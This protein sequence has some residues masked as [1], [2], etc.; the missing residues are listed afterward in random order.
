V[1]DFACWV[2][3]VER[4]IS[5][6]FRFCNCPLPQKHGVMR[7]RVRV[8]VCR[9]IDT[10]MRR[11]IQD[12]AVLGVTSGINLRKSKLHRPMSVLT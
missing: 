7:V 1:V 8:S 2:E 11:V 5:Q 3:V 4:D 9:D 10:W 12:I 6:A